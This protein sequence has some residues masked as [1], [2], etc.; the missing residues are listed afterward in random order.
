[1]T[2]VFDITAYGAVG[3]GKTD[4]T[5][6]IQQA[7][8]DAAK[9]EGKVVVPA[10]RYLT[11]R[12]KM[13]IRTRLEGDSAWNFRADGSS[14]FLLN[15]PEAVCLLDITGAFGCSISG[16][17]FDGQKLGT[18]IHGIYLYWERYNGGSEEDTP[19][20][21]DC[22]VG[23]FSG[24]GVH[25]EHIWC[26]S[27]RHSMLHRNGG[28]GL[29]IDGWDA[30]IMDNWFTANRHSGI[31]G[32]PYTASVTATGNRVEWNRESGFRFRNG[33]SVNI[34]GNFFDR[35]FGPAVKLGGGG[36]FR[37]VT[38]TGNM[39]R[40]SGCPDGMEFAS[41]YENSHVYFDNAQNVTLTGNTFKWGV[42]DD[43]RGTRSPDYDVYMV[44]STAV[45]I[46]SNVMFQGA[47]RQ[48]IVYDGNGE[49]IIKDN[50]THHKT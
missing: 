8:D 13:G 37:D 14:V 43:G 34:T 44:N 26:F 24:D 31:L 19:A 1:M 47:L 4:C 16:M 23:N 32:G 29:Y 27:V 50:L 22:R 28:A 12:L 45:V 17:C 49:N 21:D 20:I 40:R 15:D 35:S 48:S 46:Q 18:N 42:N 33:D 36:Q 39:F 10:G 2:N 5:A 3:D 30:F 38:I 11:G 6:A 41:E 7:L 9:V 25:L